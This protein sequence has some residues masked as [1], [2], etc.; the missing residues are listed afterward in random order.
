[1]TADDYLTRAFPFRVRPRHLETLDSYSRRVLERNGEPSTLPRDLL[2]RAAPDTT[3][4]QVLT[5]KTG[6]TL[7]RLA[8]S[9][10]PVPTHGGETCGVCQEALPPRWMCTFCA[11]GAHIEQWPHVAAFICERH[12]RWTGPGT[13][14]DQQHRVSRAAVLAHRRFLRLRRANRIDAQVLARLVTSL[15]VESGQCLGAVFPSAVDI[16][17]WLGEPDTLEALFDPT[18]GYETSFH[19]LSSGVTRYAGGERPDTLRALWLFLRPA[20]IALRSA[21]RERRPYAP[22]NLHDFTIPE[23]VAATFPR[24]DALPSFSIYLELTGDS[25]LSALTHPLAPA[26]PSGREQPSP[27]TV[28]CT[29][30]HEFDV[31]RVRFGTSKMSLPGCPVCSNRRIVRGENDLASV[32]PVVAAQLHPDLNNGLRADGVAARS[33]KSLWWRC[34]RGHDYTATPSNRTLT[35][36]GC[37]VCLNRVIVAGQN[38]IATTHPS[39]AAEWHPTATNQRMPHEVGAG[40]KREINWLCAEG[41]EYTARINE[42]VNGRTCPECRKA[43]V[44]ASGKNLA[45]THPTL[46]AQW[47]PEVNDGEDPRSYTHG[48]AVII[49]WTCELGHQYP[50]RIEARTRGGG[51]PFCSGRRLLAGHNDL[52]TTHPRLADEWS[53]RNRKMPTEVQAGSNV[54]HYWRCRNGHDTRQSTPNR[55]LSRGCTQCPP[56]QRALRNLSD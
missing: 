7:D 2:R 6:R 15:A 36:S 29:N 48:S 40:D 34:P 49:T 10:L 26:L 8:R 46:A 37:P 4:E 22:K 12:R 33:G 9:P 13:E 51:C 53:Y 28:I 18:T 11:Q 1:M 24:P 50:M 41:H 42:R 32:A 35:D 3:W 44:R 23:H 52:S 16:L 20:Y 25:A 47:L 30:G 43:Q 39:I 14:P 27:V 38:D 5:A 56:A 31:P 55:I 54:L 17:T 19:V 21:H 45:D